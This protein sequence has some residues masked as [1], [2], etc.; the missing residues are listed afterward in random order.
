[1]RVNTNVWRQDS[2]MQ[3]VSGR[4]LSLRADSSVETAPHFPPVDGK[5][6]AACW[7]KQR[8]DVWSSESSSPNEAPRC[9]QINKLQVKAWFTV[10]T[11]MHELHVVG[12]LRLHYRGGSETV[13]KLQ[14]QFLPLMFLLYISLQR[15]TCLVVNRFAYYTFTPLHSFDRFSCHT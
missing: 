9:K 15:L 8:R 14:N 5:L 6:P 1:M 3:V 11:T 4:A 12:I 7:K 10:F 13:G 2:L